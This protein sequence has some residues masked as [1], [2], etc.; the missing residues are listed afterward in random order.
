MTDLSTG[1]VA[2]LL[3]VRRETVWRWASR[4][5]SQKEVDRG[6][7][8]TKGGHYRFTA[9]AVELLRKEHGKEEGS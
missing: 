2:K 5:G 3:G 8:W 6:I 4:V 1:Q 9:E 7:R